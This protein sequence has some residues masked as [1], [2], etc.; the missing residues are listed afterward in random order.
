MKGEIIEISRIIDENEMIRGYLIV[1][2]TKDV[3]NL[4]LGN[5]DITQK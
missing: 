3:P 1:V 5:C 2:E 4:K